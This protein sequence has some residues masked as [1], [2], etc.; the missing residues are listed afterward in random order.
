MERRQRLRP[1]RRAESR[2]RPRS[3]RG[4]VRRRT[5]GAAARGRAVDRFHDFLQEGYQYQP[6]VEAAP[7]PTALQAIAASNFEIIY[8]QLAGQRISSAR[9][10]VA[11]RDVPA[12]GAI[13]R[14]RARQQTHRRAAGSR[15]RADAFPFRSPSS[16][17]VSPYAPRPTHRWN[18]LAASCEPVSR[19]RR[20]SSSHCARSHQS[21]LRAGAG[22]RVCRSGPG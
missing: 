2:P 7:S 20:R 1:V 5:G 21:A 11:A 12:P 4:D 14:R 19:P 8:R 10:P 16:T 9:R 22:S 15:H 17:I 3:V 13:P 6:G 18:P